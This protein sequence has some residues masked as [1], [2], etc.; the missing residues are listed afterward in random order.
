[1]PINQ[2]HCPI[3][4]AHMVRVTDSMA[5]PC[6]MCLNYEKESGACRLEPSAPEGVR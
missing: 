3:S 2:I 1:M 6:M 5:R 4:P